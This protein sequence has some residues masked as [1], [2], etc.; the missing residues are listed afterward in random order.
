MDS[1]VAVMMVVAWS[2][3]FVSVCVLPTPRELK[4]TSQIESSQELRFAITLLM[5]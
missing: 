5:L 2:F 3:R 1:E 4:I